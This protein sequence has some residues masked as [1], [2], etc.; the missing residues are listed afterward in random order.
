MLGESN[1]IDE[2]KSR[3]ELMIALIKLQAIALLTKV[4]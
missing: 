4:T 2:C 1:I 3:N